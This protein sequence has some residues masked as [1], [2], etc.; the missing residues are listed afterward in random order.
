[1]TPTVLVQV[2]PILGLSV[3]LR[4]VVA[5][6]A[7]M[8]RSSLPKPSRFPGWSKLQ[9]R[10]TWIVVRRSAPAGLGTLSAGLSAVAPFRLIDPQGACKVAWWRSDLRV[11]GRARGLW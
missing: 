9:K 6:H 1:V 5:M 2:W 10:L 4:D 7:H 8:V 3:A 11:L